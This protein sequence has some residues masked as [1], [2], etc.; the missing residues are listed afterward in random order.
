MQKLHS[1]FLCAL[2]VFVVINEEFIDAAADSR[3]RDR[4][5]EASIRIEQF[6]VQRH[7]AKRVRGAGKARIVAADAGFYPVQHSFRDLPFLS[8]DEVGRDL[9][10]RAVHRNIILRR[11]DDEVRLL[12]H[13]VLVHLVPVEQHTARRLAESDTFRP[14]DRRL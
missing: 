1:A 4:I 14:V 8:V 3:S 11:C 7:L 12:D 6:H 13:T 9:M 10:H 2:S 5:E